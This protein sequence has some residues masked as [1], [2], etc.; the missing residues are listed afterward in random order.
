LF[1]F[2]VYFY[3]SS[4]IFSQR[5]EGVSAVHY[6]DKVIS[7]LCEKSIFSVLWLRDADTDRGSL[8]ESGAFWIL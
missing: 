5:L 6:L 7:N 3:I 4:D 1:I 8:L 2:I